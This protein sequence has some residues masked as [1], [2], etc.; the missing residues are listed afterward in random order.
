MKLRYFYQC[1]LFRI[2]QD[3]G[4]SSH[5]KSQVFREFQKRSVLY[6]TLLVKL[7]AFSFH[8]TALIKRDFTT[9]PFLEVSQTFQKISSLYGLK[10]VFHKFYLVHSWI[11]DKY[12]PRSVISITALI[13]FVFG[14]ILVRIFSHS[15]WVRRDT[16]Y[17]PYSVQMR[18]NTE[19]NSSEYRHFLRNVYL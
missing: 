9:D 18:E 12:H 10:V 14:V 5:W 2:N 17:S 1:Y 11:L 16:K 7:Q 4:R 3:A 8:S 6:S 13:V 19:Q 15:D